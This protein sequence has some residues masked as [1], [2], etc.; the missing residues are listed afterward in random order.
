MRHKDTIWFHGAPTYHQ[1]KSIFWD[2][3]KLM[4]REWRTYKSDSELYVK[5]INGS[6]IHV[7]GLDSPE[8]IE[9]RT[10]S[11]NGC[12]LAEFADLKPEAW[13][14]NIRP[15]LADTGGSAIID[16]VPD[17]YKPGFF[18]HRKMAQF[19]CGGTIPSTVSY[20]GAYGEN[21]E[22]CFYT[23]WSE[24]VLKPE[25][26]KAIKEETDPQTYSIEYEG[27]FESIGGRVYYGYIPDYYPAGNLDTSIHYDKHLP[28]VMAF[29]FNVNPM[30][31]VLG[32]VRVN[33]DC[34]QEYHAFK[35][36]YL[37]DSNTKTLIDRIIAE[38]IDTN[39]FYL[40]PCQSSIARQ[41]SQEINSD[42]YRTDLA[43]IK[44]AM[45]S[46]KKNLYIK[47]RPKNPLEHKAIRALNSIL[48]NKRLRFNPNCIALKELQN[49]FEKLTYKEGTS[50]IDDTDKM[51]NHIS[52][53]LSYLCE[54]YWPVKTE[55]EKDE[56]DEEDRQPLIL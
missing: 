27:S 25:E 10:K 37:R 30:T 26:I 32:H 43:I 29:D 21:G 2:D 52:K 38:H 14:Q 6:E 20:D 23:W 5:L 3:V 39:T 12:H 46:A 36:Y 48:C 11:W 18:N 17:P 19:A 45:A 56:E 42:G 33:K 35:G 50:A 15:V 54:K 9:G 4:T 16:G 13:A 22:W 47:K 44:T 7:I 34:K 55:I 28:V 1:A 41:S 24:D 8:R 31:A 51:R 49:D 53:A 40:T